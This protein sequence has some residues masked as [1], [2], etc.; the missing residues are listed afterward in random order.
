MGFSMTSPKECLSQFTEYP[1]SAGGV[2]TLTQREG[3]LVAWMKANGQTWRTVPPGWE[4]PPFEEASSSPK[5]LAQSKHTA[6]T[7]AITLSASETIFVA[8]LFDRFM[9]FISGY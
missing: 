3:W 5:P 6:V 7:P 8:T 4:P 2:I 1:D 9:N